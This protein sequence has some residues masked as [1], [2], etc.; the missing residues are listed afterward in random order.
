MTSTNALAGLVNQPGVDQIAEPLSKA[1]RG[2]FAAAGPAGRHI[3][4]ALHGT[5]L[6][7]PLHPVFTDVPIGAWTTA[8]AL[9]V[10]AAANRDRGLERAADFAVAV[11]LAGA[12]GAAVTGLTDWSET[13]GGARRKGLA[14]GLMN[15]A[16]TSLFAI[17]YVLRKQG[18]RTTGQACS[19][20]GYAVAMAAAYIG[21]SLVH[22]DRIGVTHAAID[23]PD[24]FVP[25]AEAA[26][27]AENAMMHVRTGDA[28]ILVVRQHRRLC[29]LAHSC[30]HLGGPLSEGT[31]NDGSVVCPWHGSAFA[32]KDGRV[33][34]GPA[35]IDQPCL[36]VRERDGRIEVKA[37]EP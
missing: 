15:I 31:L 35:T 2:A 10:A 27:L 11:G 21:G 17:S 19:T 9:D 24:H 3:K 7:H 25:V 6:G 18:A 33:L 20:T 29:A 13:D 22:D 16:A 34:N 23:P 37:A 1:V 28:N 5:W 8:M 26:A 14:H 30:S 32:L 4:N 36:A 12:V